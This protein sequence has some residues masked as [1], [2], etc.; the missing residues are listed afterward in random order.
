MPGGVSRPEVGGF[1]DLPHG[2]PL[3]QSQQVVP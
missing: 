2:N 1:P 3:R